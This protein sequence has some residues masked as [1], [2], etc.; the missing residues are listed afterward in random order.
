MKLR[1]KGES[2]AYVSRG[3]D[4]KKVEAI[5][6]EMDKFEFDYMP[7]G[8][9]THHENYPQTV[10]TGKFDDLDIAELCRRCWNRCIYIWVYDS[11]ATELVYGPATGTT[12]G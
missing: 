1:R 3:S 8:W 4:V 11:S 6:C 12:A 10:Y 2:R 9:V 7:E 5:I